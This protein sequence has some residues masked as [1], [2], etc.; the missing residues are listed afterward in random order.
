M[1]MTETSWARAKRRTVPAAS[2]ASW[3]SVVDPPG[4]AAIQARLRGSGTALQDLV[5]D[6]LQRPGAEDFEDDAEEQECCRQGENPRA[7]RGA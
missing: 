6:H 2:Q 4:S 5:N 7:C 1:T 3:P